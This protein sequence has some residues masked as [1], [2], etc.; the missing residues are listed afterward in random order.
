METQSLNDVR[1]GFYFMSV[2][3]YE[4]AVTAFAKAV[5]KNPKEANYYLFLGRALYWSGKVDSAMAE[6]RTAM[7]INPKNGD[8]YQLLGIGYGWKGDIR[9]A[10]KN[11]EKAERL[12]PN[13]PDVKMNLSSVYASQN[14]LELALDYIRMAVALSPK[15][16]LLYHQ[17]GL[18]S[19]MLGRDS[20]AEEAFKT[21]IKLYP[22]YEDSMLA[23]A[24]T[25]EKR[26]DDKDALSYYKK[27]LKIKPEDYVARLR[28]A[29]LLFTSAFEK[30]AKEVVEKAFSISS[31]E[32]KGL[33][34]NVS[35]SAVQNQT[36]QS[37]FPPELSA[38]K[39][40]LEETDLA[41]DIIVDAEV[42]YSLPHEFKEAKEKSLLERE[43]LRA[44]EQSRAAAAG[45]QT[46]RR[47]FIINGAN[48][49]ERNIQIET[50]I[51]TLSE[52]LQNSPENTQSKLNVKTEN[53][54]KTVPVEGTGG[55]S[56]QK[57]AY[58]PRN[59]GND[60]GLW[61]AG[62]SW[63]RFVAETLPDIENRIFDKEQQKMEPDSFD[64]V[65]MGLAYLT[66]GKGNEA[67]N[68]F[69]DALKTEPA[70]ELALL[71]KGTA[72]IVLGREDNAQ[73]IYRQVLEINPKNKTAKKN[74]TFLEKRGA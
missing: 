59:V 9:Q 28:Y 33:A 2:A 66:L 20:S 72:W 34:F 32:G 26:N 64:N 40:V 11:F 73:N 19:E 1:K 49:E 8:A 57:T 38:L 36:A 7:E 55:N 24:A 44:L 17:L 21:S 47:S 60:M 37:S 74:L 48:K 50:I 42:N 62:K 14:K 23:L 35:Y 18:I 67:L 31:R 16:P 6:F 12:M 53:A 71:G 29:N 69:D 10:Q 5:V 41:D 68:Y 22:R 25:Y 15:D 13:R 4:D 51:N 65:L 54:K 45:S 30:E 27:A 43:M 3:K 46:F 58:D 39:K 52:A 56:S 70:N 63:V 61:V